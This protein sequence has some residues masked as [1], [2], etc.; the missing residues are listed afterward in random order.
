[1][2]RERLFGSEYE[3]KARYVPCLLLLTPAIVA[4]AF[5]FDRYSGG[6]GIERCVRIL[7]GVLG[8]AGIG[9][10]LTVYC[11]ANKMREKGRMLQARYFKSGLELPT[12]RMM[13]WNDATFS[14]E[15]KKYLRK[16]VFKQFGIR[17][18]TEEDEHND[19]MRAGRLI[20][21]TVD[22]IRP[23]IKDGIRLLQY[24]I[25]FG[26]ERN[27]DACASISFFVAVL[28]MMVC[29]FLEGYTFACCE[30]ALAVWFAFRWL[31]TPMRIVWYGEEYARVFWAEFAAMYVEKVVC[32]ETGLTNEIPL[33]G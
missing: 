13:M 32:A 24:N 31:R 19:P 22:M 28:G 18:P 11:L 16:L 20:S 21:E 33:K 10:P 25:R 14:N 5:L 30:M 8:S 7:I 6:S 26:S 12:T 1:M 2:V 15:Y 4:A 23:K 17:L 27:I 3:L 9:W 29:L